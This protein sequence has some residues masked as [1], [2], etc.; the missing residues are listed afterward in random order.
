MHIGGK[1]FRSWY[2]KYQL[3]KRQ[4]NTECSR[5]QTRQS[6]PS[7]NSSRLDLLTRSSMR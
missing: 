3:T 5:F 1:R 2:T 6:G 7:R 4:Q